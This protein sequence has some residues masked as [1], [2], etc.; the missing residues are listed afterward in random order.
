MDEIQYYTRG[1]G[2]VYWVAPVKQKVGKQ[3]YWSWK[4]VTAQPKSKIMRRPEGFVAVAVPPAYADSVDCN[5]YH[6]PN[7]PR[8]VFNK[9][10]EAEGWLKLTCERWE[11]G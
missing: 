7:L 2:Y 1:R 6:I 10:A 3:T 11:W 4:I 5:P 9:K 8:Y